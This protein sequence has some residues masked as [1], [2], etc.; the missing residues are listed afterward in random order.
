MSI[1]THWEHGKNNDLIFLRQ[2][3]EIRKKHV[4]SIFDQPDTSP[5]LV[6]LCLESFPDVQIWYL[7]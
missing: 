7:I 3:R 6:I 5:V 1:P 2:T 4:N